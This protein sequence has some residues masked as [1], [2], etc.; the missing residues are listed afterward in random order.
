MNL[1]RPLLRDITWTRV[2]LALVLTTV[3][4]A[5]VR[6]YFNYDISF[7]YL[8]FRM[9]IVTVVMLVLF[10]VAGVIHENMAHPPMTRLRAQF[11]AM[12]AGAFIGPVVSGLL[13]GRSFSE[14]FTVEPMFWGMVFFTTVSIAMA[15][16]TGTL[17]VYRARA[18]KAETEIA[19]AENKQKPFIAYR[20]IDFLLKK[21]T[22]L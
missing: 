16:A 21:M 4:T 20:H 11:V 1:L 17:L 22:T 3:A 5:I 9:F 18:A 6:P 12:G 10:L 8:W 2:L 13:I 19:R 15:V 14:M 7:D